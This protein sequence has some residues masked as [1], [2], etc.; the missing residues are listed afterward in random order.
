MRLLFERLCFKELELF[1]IGY[2]PKMNVLSKHITNNKIYNFSNIC[3]KN[4]KIR[5]QNKKK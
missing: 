2:L 4:L 5:N 1:K 3:I